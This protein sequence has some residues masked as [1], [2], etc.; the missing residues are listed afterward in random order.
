MKFIKT[1]LIVI[2]SIFFVSNVQA[3]PKLAKI[4]P[5]SIAFKANDINN[6]AT[7][8]LY[9]YGEGYKIRFNYDDGRAFEYYI[10]YNDIRY[11]VHELKFGDDISLKAS[12]EGWLFSFEFVR[13]LDSKEI[14]NPRLMVTEIDSGEVFDIWL[15]PKTVKDLF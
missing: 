12:S 5:S 11:D 8:T 15:N 3:A 9:H 7:F 6:T 1:M 14:L 10:D 2:A 4:D 13:P